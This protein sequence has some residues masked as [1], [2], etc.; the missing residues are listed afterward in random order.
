MGQPEERH[1]IG[2]IFYRCHYDGQMCNGEMG[3]KEYVVERW[4]ESKAIEFIHCE[5]R[6][7]CKLDGGE[8]QACMR[9][10]W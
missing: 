5:E 6:C 4:T 7:K 1:S 9:K 3:K 10:L 2:A 8:E